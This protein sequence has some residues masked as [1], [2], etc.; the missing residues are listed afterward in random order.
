MAPGCGFPMV[1]M[2]EGYLSVPPSKNIIPVYT[3]PLLSPLNFH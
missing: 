1:H 2:A 3:I